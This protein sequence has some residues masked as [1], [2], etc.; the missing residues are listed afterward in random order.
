MKLAIGGYF[1]ANIYTVDGCHCV[2]DFSHPAWSK[3]V[4]TGPGQVDEEIVS[5]PIVKFFRTRRF[6]RVWIQAVGALLG[7]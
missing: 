5:Q 7:G 3:R 2:F 1:W 6:G 4:E